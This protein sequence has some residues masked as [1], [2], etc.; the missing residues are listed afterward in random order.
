MAHMA[1]GTDA[2]FLHIHTAANHR[3]ET[4]S[5]MSVLESHDP[6]LASEFVRWLLAKRFLLQKILRKGCSYL[7]LDTTGLDVKAGPAVANL[8]PT[9]GGGYSRSKAELSEVYPWTWTSRG[10]PLACS[11]RYPGPFPQEKVCVLAA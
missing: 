4:L 3:S 2:L 9:W 8:P 1:Y 11:Q 7:P 10:T 6:V 5:A